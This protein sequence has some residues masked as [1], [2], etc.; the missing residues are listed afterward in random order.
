MHRVGVLG[1]RDLKM[2]G[3]NKNL[4]TKEKRGIG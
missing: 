4:G 3:K 1:R 2:P